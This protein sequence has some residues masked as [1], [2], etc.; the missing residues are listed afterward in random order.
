MMAHSPFSLE[1]S[2]ARNAARPRHWRASLTPAA[3]KRSASFACARACQ[4]A[5]QATLACGHQ[6]PAKCL[7]MLTQ[8]IYTERER[9]AN[10]HSRSQQLQ[11]LLCGLKVGGAY[12]LEHVHLAIAHA[13][14]G[15]LQQFLPQARQHAWAR[16]ASL[17]CARD[18]S[19]CCYRGRCE[20]SSGEASSK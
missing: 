11:R 17:H 20:A 3:L 2:C 7:H 16:V 6:V 19:A 5:F 15:V 14:L 18:A 10:M 4:Y 1:P 8:S 9:P 12:Y 13:P